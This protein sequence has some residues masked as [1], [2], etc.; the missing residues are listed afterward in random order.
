MDYFA[1]AGEVR[2]RKA[3]S[4]EAVRLKNAGTLREAVCGY[5]IVTSLY[6][7]IKPIHILTV[8]EAFSFKR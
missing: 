8:N 5:C 2:G 7:I 3:R 4:W 6:N 1:S